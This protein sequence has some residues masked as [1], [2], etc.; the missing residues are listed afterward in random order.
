MTNFPNHKDTRNDQLGLESRW[1]D[2]EAVWVLVGSAGA[3]LAMQQF[4]NAFEVPP[5]V[6]F[7]YA[8]HYDPGKQDQL[9]Q[10]TTENPLFKLCLAEG[11][12]QLEPGKVLMMPPRGKV[13]ID[14]SGAVC[15]TGDPWEGEHTP[16]IDELLI[17]FSAANLPGSGVIFF[18]GMGCDG[19]DVLNVLDAAGTRI[20]AQTPQSAICSAMPQAALNTGLVHRT[21][22]PALLANELVKLYLS[23]S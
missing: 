2:V 22:T 23:K 12:H 18:S 7:I 14:T 10:L 20:W 15:S 13:T 3:G 1:Q 21:G 9:Q 16:D 4:F 17:I 5:P 19:A 11:N 6:A 8:Q